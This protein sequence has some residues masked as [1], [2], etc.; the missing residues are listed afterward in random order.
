MKLGLS[1]HQ[2][3]CPPLITFEP[4]GNL[5]DIWY[6]DDA[7]QVDLDA[8]IFN[9][10]ASTILKWLRFNVVSW[11]H[12]LQPCTEMIWDSLIVGL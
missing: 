5:H 9:P 8:I 11:R 1:N 10:I 4:L 2:S 3:V 7:I 6:G 12:A